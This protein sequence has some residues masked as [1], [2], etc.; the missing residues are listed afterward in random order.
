ETNGP[1]LV[2]SKAHDEEVTSVL[3]LDKQTL[4]SGGYH[5]VDITQEVGHPAHRSIGEVRFW[6]AATGKRLRELQPE[7]TN[8]GGCSIA[9]SRDGK[10]L[11]PA[12]P[13]TVRLWPLPDGRPLRQIR[14]Y[15][16]A[17]GQH[18]G[19]LGFSPDGKRLA[20]RAGDHVIR[21]WDVT[22]GERVLAFP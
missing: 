5:R 17:F 2:I 13:D 4:V 21:V 12:Y 18:A 15:R 10:P 19:D 11:A 20:A 6:E 3:F 22:T 8:A 1:P 16:N 14:D 7:A 9:L